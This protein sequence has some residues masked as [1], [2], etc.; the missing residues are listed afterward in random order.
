MPGVV[1]KWSQAQGGSG[2]DAEYLPRPPIENEIYSARNTCWCRTHTVGAVDTGGTVGLPREPLSHDQ[3]S[4]VQ[5]HKC[6]QENRTGSKEHAVCVCVCVSGVVLSAESLC[7][8]SLGHKKCPQFK[9]TILID[10]F[11]HTWRGHW[12]P[13]REP[14]SA[15]H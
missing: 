2:Q 10:I 13:W 6:S 5:G 8:N 14:G 11:H 1:R 9:F 12:P 7:H 15:V 4:Q 3:Y